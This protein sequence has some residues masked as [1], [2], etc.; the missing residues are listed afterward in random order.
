MPE[1]KQPVPGGQIL[2]RNGFT[3]GSIFPGGIF[4][5]LPVLEAVLDVIEEQL[6]EVVLRVELVVI[7]DAGPGHDYASWPVNAA[8]T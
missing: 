8:T 3:L 7:D 4:G 5:L 6:A 1:A 2:F